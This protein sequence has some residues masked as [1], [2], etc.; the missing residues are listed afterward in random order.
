MIRALHDLFSE[1]IEA[2][3]HGIIYG[4]V[5]ATALTVVFFTLKGL[6]G[7]AAMLKGLVQ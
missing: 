7:W 4:I 3:W 1:V 2:V 6:S 5:A